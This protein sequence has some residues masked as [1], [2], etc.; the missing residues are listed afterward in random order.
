MDDSSLANMSNM[1]TDRGRQCVGCRFIC[2]DASRC[3][4]GRGK[5][6]DN[7]WE[8][9]PKRMEGR[10]HRTTWGSSTDPS[11]A[12]GQSSCPGPCLQLQVRATRGTVGRLQPFSV[13]D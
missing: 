8:G 13:S 11:A 7:N 1:V 6:I 9:D 5:G 2:T 3:R 4:G 12:R 10:V